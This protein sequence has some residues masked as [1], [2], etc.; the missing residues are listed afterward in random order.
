MAG[1]LTH[2]PLGFG[3]ECSTHYHC[4]ITQIILKS[5][6]THQIFKIAKISNKGPPMWSDQNHGPSLNRSHRLKLMQ[7]PSH[8]DYS[9]EPFY[10]T[11]H[12]LQYTQ[13]YNQLMKLGNIPDVHSDLELLLV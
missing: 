5:N 10:N 12:Q 13:Y 2:Y 8:K 1:V 6:T 9:K 3:S 11:T 4:T 7:V